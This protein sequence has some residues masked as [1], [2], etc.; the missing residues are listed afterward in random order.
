MPISSAYATA[1]SQFRALRSEQHLAK[2]FALL[3]AKHYGVEFGPSQVEITFE[4]EEKALNT[5]A[6]HQQQ[7]LEDS[8]ANKRWK[9]IV[10]RQ[11]PPPTWT[12][13]QEYTRLWQEG[14][15]PTYGPIQT[16][17]QLTAPKVVLT[18]DQRMQLAKEKQIKN[19]DAF[20]LLSKRA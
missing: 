3:E 12:K 16:A 14:V 4:K 15:R 10:E 19:V 20:R 8:L 17:P 7:R 6:Q 1:V 11:G 13:G 5:F 18:S 9:A 2:R